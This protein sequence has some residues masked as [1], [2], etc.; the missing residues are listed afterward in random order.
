MCDILLIYLWI[1]VTLVSL[2]RHGNRY[3]ATVFGFTAASIPSPQKALDHVFTEVP[4][5]VPL[6]TNELRRCYVSEYRQW[7]R[8]PSG[9]G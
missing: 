5:T 1:T 3:Y 2:L 6:T 7:R 4:S 8:Q 9:S